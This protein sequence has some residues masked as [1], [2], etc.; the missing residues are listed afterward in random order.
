M[1]LF[2]E[3]GVNLLELEWQVTVN[4]LACMLGSYPGSLQEQ[5]GLLTS[6]KHLPSPT[7]YRGL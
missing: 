1:Q 2:V 4:H 3:E 6:L 7:L 5:Q